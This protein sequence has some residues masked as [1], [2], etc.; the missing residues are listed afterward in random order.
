RAVDSRRSM[1]SWRALGSL[2]RISVWDAPQFETRPARKF[3][4]RRCWCTVRPRLE[5]AGGA[6]AH[7]PDP[8]RS[9]CA[10]RP[11]RPG[12]RTGIRRTSTSPLSGAFSVGMGD[13][14]DMDHGK[15]P[16]AGG[17]AVAPANVHHYAWTKTGA[18]IQVHLNGP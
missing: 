12:R 8:R 16:K 15:T 10:P 7:E 4:R 17:Y 13:K 11:R 18:T 3:S 14:L 1:R 9:V 2:G 5:H 6:P